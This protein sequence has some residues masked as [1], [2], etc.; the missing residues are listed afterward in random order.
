[1]KEK[2]VLERDVVVG[3]IDGLYEEKDIDVRFGSLER[4]TDIVLDHLSNVRFLDGYSDE[5]HIDHYKAVESI[6][7]NLFEQHFDMI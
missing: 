4:A 3:I 5:A 7:E 1:M 2:L 6:L